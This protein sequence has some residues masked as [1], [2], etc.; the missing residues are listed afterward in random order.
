MFPFFPRLRY[1]QAHNRLSLR[2]I[3]LQLPGTVISQPLEY[4]KKNTHFLRFP[5]KELAAIGNYNSLCCG[6]WLPIF[7][8]L[9]LPRFV[10]A[11]RASHVVSSL[12]SVGVV[13]E[14]RSS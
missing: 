1:Y 7:A 10:S 14:V 3:T 11:V 12:V 5:G 8:R 9:V 6:C 4:I 2:E 13:R